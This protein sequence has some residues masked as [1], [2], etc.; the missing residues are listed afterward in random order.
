MSATTNDGMSV[1]SATGHPPKLRRLL[2]VAIACAVLLAGGYAIWSAQSMIVSDNA[3]VSA[4]VTSLRAPIEGYVSAS[5]I[6]VGAAIDRGV[7]LATVSNPRVDDQLL[8]QLQER[9]HRLALEKTAIVRQ[10]ASF[11]AT[12]RD[13]MQRGEVYRQ[14]LLARLAGQL[15]E[16]RMARA[17]KLSEAEQA[18]RD[19]A[20]KQDL[21]RSGTASLS[22]LEKAQY[23]FES[24]DR[25]AQSLAGQLASVQAQIDAA[26]VGVMTD[27]GGNDVIYSV[28]RADEVRLRI[29]EL[30]RAMDTVNSDANEANARLA[31]ESHRIEL[32]RSAS[33]AAPSAGMLWKIDSSNGERLGVGDATAELVDCS[34]AFLVATIPQS[35]Y[36]DIVLGGEAR[37]R[38]SGE[39]AERTGTI[40]SVTSDTSLIGDHNLAA[41]PVDQHRPTAIVRIAVPSSRNVG[42][43]CLVGRSARVLLPTIQRS[44]PDLAMRLVRRF[45]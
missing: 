5:R 16:T 6:P 35:A 3:V 22:D 11:E 26:T 18:K 14:A 2:K 20:R 1:G 19:Y 13:L 44:A 36:A 7:V 25:Q 15:D 28:Q 45:F 43:E 4:Y 34:A 29:T 31:D 30:D 23:G 33:I 8:T 12:W 41:V 39:S 42:A 40:L 38:L 32:L 10:R 21:A 24:L 9:V 27:A 17:A 37:F